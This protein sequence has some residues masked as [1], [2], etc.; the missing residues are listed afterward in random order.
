MLW[1]WMWLQGTFEMYASMKHAPASFE[2]TDHKY[3]LMKGLLV[4]WSYH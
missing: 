1:L 4:N 3:P 2:S